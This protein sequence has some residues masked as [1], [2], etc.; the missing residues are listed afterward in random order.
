VCVC[1]KV[2]SYCRLDYSLFLSVSGRAM[3]ILNVPSAGFIYVSC[4]C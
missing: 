4:L 1:V 2:I 3:Q